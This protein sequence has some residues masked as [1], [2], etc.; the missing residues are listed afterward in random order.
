MKLVQL[1]LNLSPEEI[2]PFLGI[3]SGARL[4]PELMNLIQHYLQSIKE[5]A[6]PQGLWQTYAVKDISPER[7]TLETSPLVIEGMKT[8]PHF[9]TSV[10]VS[11][12]AVTLGSTIDHL[13]EELGQRE[14]THALILD[15]VASA[16]VEEMAEQLDQHISREIRR[17]GY[18]PTARFSPGY[19]DWPLSW[20]KAFLESIDAWKINLG[21]TPHCLL[22]PVKSITAAIGWSRFPVERNYELPAKKK[23]CQGTLSCQNCPLSAV[24]QRMPDHQLPDL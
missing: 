13:L 14:P 9:D 5:L 24:C 21:V 12:L 1:P 19:G 4:A 15:G 11:L 8:V 17:Q 2:F 20:Q 10:K 7:I 22:Q 3:T 18:F 16:A 6:K 23:P